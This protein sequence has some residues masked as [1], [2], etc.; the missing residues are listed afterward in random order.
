LASY[1]DPRGP[2]GASA[3]Q[4][5]LR[6]APR[7]AP[8]SR[9]GI[10]GRLFSGTLFGY[11]EEGDPRFNAAYGAASAMS[12]GQESLAAWQAA[13]DLDSRMLDVTVGT[14]EDPGRARDIGIAFAVLASV[15]LVPAERDGAPATAVKLVLLKPGV[16]HD[17]L[18]LLARTLGLGDIVL[19]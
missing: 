11:A 9:G 19:Y 14:F 13:N 1:N 4:A 17:D 6:A 3:A 18:N 8:P 16:T 2:S 10:F 15:D 7:E 5:I 12:E